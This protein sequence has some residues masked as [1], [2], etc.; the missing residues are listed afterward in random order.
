M[1]R[2]GLMESDNAVLAIPACVHSQMSHG[3]EA[4][5]YDGHPR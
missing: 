5:N 1:G 4:V 2:E 3:N